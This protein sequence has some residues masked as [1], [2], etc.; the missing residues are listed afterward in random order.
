MIQAPVILSVAA[1][2]LVVPVSLLMTND[3]VAA[4]PVIE[5]DTEHPVGNVYVIVT[6]P[7]KIRVTRPVNETV[8]IPVSLLVH[9]PPVVSS[10]KADVSH[11]LTYVV[12][13]IAVGCGFTVI[14]TVPLIGVDH[15]PFVPTTV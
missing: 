5:T 12:Q 1:R 4:G 14:V 11:I 8:T 6:V 15:Q 10:V 13:V 7:S 2:E 3:Q 9:V